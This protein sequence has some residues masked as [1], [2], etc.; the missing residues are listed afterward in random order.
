MHEHT[1]TLHTAEMQGYGVA[2]L[3]GDTTG[4]GMAHIPY[5]ALKNPRTV[6]V[7]VCHCG[8]TGHFVKG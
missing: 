6:F 4:P 5:G 2:P 3:K 8:E 1:W 7:P